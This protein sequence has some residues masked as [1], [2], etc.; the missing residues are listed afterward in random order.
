MIILGFTL[1]L[2]DTKLGQYNMLNEI[3]ERLFSDEKKTCFTASNPMHA[4][5]EWPIT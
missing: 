1:T 4:S 2:N 5:Q 3:Y